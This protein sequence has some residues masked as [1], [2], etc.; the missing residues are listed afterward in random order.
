MENLSYEEKQIVIACIKFT[1]DTY[2]K[3]PVK[4]FNK[5]IKGVVSKQQLI[6]LVNDILKKVEED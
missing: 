4:H 2:Y 1:R 6:N 3:V 5:M